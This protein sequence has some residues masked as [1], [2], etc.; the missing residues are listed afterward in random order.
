[1]S[2]KY[3]TSGTGTFSTVS[4]GYEGNNAARLVLGSSGTNIQLY[5]TG[6]TLESNTAYRLSFSAYSTTGHDMAVKLFKH[7][8]PYTAYAPKLYGKSWHETGRHSQLNLLRP[9]SQIL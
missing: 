7:V 8:S 6:I 4:P 1:M 5:Q 9:V 2:W 3:F